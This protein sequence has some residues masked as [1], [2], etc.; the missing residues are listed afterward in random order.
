MDCNIVDFVKA[1]LPLLPFY[2]RVLILRRLDK[3]FLFVVSYFLLDFIFSTTVVSFLTQIS[4]IFD[5]TKKVSSKFY[6][7]CTNAMHSHLKSVSTDFK[8]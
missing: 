7:C 4:E 1:M 2:K 5:C 8:T 6:W 3:E